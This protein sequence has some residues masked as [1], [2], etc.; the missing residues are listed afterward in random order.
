MVIKQL[1]STVIVSHSCLL[2]QDSLAES[3]LQSLQFLIE[4]PNC[5]LSLPVD[6][7]GVEKMIDAVLASLPIGEMLDLTKEEFET[8][9]DK[10]HFIERK[11][12]LLFE[13]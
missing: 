5:M 11:S 9:D 1:F 8:Y 12:V 10:L 4:N 13:P 2:F 6:I 7:K 3:V